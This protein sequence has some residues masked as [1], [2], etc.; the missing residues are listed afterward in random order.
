M[1]G[2]SRLEIV[3]TEVHL[4]MLGWRR[5]LLVLRGDLRSGVWVDLRGLRPRVRAVPSLLWRREVWGL[6]LLLMVVLLLRVVYCSWWLN[7]TMLSG[8]SEWESSSV[9]WRL[10]RVD[11]CRSRSLP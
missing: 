10:H 6:L 11:D 4:R 2:V 9:E 1:S 5:T 8:W 7:D 3:A